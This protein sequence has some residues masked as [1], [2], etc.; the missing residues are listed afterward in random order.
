MPNWCNNSVTF[1]H[2]SER[3]LDRLV[4]A[5]NENRL[6]N[7]FLP[8]PEELRETTAPNDKNADEMIEKY[9]SADWYSWQVN[10]WGTK[11]DVESVDQID[12]GDG[13]MDVTVYFDSAWSP[14][15]EFYRAMEEMGWTVT[16]YYYEP[17]MAFCGKYEDGIEYHHDILGDSAWVKENIP[18]DINETFDIAGSM[19]VWEEDER[20][21]A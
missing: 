4:K 17:G 1:S 15:L 6:F 14:P 20:D 16:A 18:E 8:C 9:G 10:N 13:Q 21:N 3:E 12:R 2:G 5:Y 19:E 7:E 11:W